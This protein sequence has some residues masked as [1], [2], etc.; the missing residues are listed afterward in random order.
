M[1]TTGDKD[2]LFS[3]LGNW[4]KEG[5]SLG[6]VP[7]MGALHTGH[8]ALVHEARST[9]ARVVVSIFVNPLQFNQASDLASYPRMPAE[10]ARLL[11]AAGADLLYAPEAAAF[12]P[13]EIHTHIDFGPVSAGLEGKMRPGHFSGVGIV[14]SR[15]FHLIQPDMAFFGA[16]DLQQVAVVRALVRDLGFPVRIVRC[17]TVREP[18]GL[19]LSSRNA[20]LSPA[21]RER[22]AVLYR[23]LEAAVG[24]E[25]EQP[26]SGRPAGMRV[27]DTEPLLETEYFELVDAS[28]MEILPTRLAG[29]EPAFCLAARLEGVRLID[30]CLL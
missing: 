11:E 15:L 16:K 7:T 26:G 5:H 24:A 8:L 29:S 21:G 12:Y 13:E 27:L 9:C 17:P 20:R 28:T 22:A 2:F 14:L 4:K 30:N 19:A 3:T 6:F 18:S 1:I 23:A 25:K 10:D